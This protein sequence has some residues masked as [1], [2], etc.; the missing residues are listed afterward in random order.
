VETFQLD[1]LLHTFKKEESKMG[2]TYKTILVAVDGSKEAE[3]AFKKA[4]EMAKRYDSKLIL[5]HIVDTRTFATVGA[6]DATFAEKANCYA[7]ELIEGYKAEA[8][9]AGITHVI[10][11]I[12]YG[13]PKLKIPKDLAKKFHAD[14]I[15][16]GATG[17]N[18]VERIFIGS[19]S[20]SIT[21]YAPCDVLVVRTQ[22]D[23]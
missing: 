19:V 11:E 18:M 8:E 3:W 1:I 22:K 7:G 20:E 14:L 16:C 9:K 12:D 23:S 4:I 17:L 2:L 5:A 15:I 10:S 21:R 13:S 6:Y